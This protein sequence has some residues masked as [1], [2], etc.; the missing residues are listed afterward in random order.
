M[1]LLCDGE[2]S[3]WGASETLQPEDGSTGG[4]HSHSHLAQVHGARERAR[5][6][7]GRR[8]CDGAPTRGAR[9][10]AAQIQRIA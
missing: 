5:V 8:S 7:L 10:R 4:E 1:A 9:H 6:H 3:F 2:D